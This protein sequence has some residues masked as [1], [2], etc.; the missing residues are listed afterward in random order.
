MSQEDDFGSIELIVEGT[1][2]KKSYGVML[3]CEPASFGDF[4]SRLLGKSQ[5]IEKNIKGNFKIDKNDILSTHHLIHQRINQQN[6]AVFIQFTARMFFSDDSSVEITTVEDFVVYNEIKKVNCVLLNVSWTYLI[7]FK[8]KSIPEKQQINITFGA[9]DYPGF[10]FSERDSKKK[11]KASSNVISV[12]IQHTERTWG[13]DME[14]LL[15]AHL[16]NFQDSDTKQ[17]KFF[18]KY[19]DKIGLFTASFFFGCSTVGAMLTLLRLARNYSNEILNLGKAASGEALL[20]KKIDYLLNITSTGV[21]PRFIL[22]LVFFMIVVLMFSIVL[23]VWVSARAESKLQSWIL[24]TENSKQQ[25]QQYL[26]SLKNNTLIF[27]GGVLV[28]IACGIIG[29]FFFAV[30]FSKLL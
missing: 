17:P 2:E 4:I 10:Y 30:Y 8:N 23:G 26:S 19:R 27:L 15:T 11:F 28:S 5:S 7:T 6:E 24:I 14:S 18:H 25:Y 16:E 12:L 29:N 22:G 20:S 3:P 13:V 9:L 21:W 1:E